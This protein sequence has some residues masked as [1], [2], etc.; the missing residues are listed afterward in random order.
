VSTAKGRPFSGNEIRR[1]L[2]HASLLKSPII[3]SAR[4]RRR[5]AASRGVERMPSLPL[6]PFASLYRV[7]EPRRNL[8]SDPITRGPHLSSRLVSSLG[9]ASL[10]VYADN[11]HIIFA[12]PLRERANNKIA[13]D[14]RIRMQSLI[15]A[16]DYC[17]VDVNCR[18][19]LPVII[20]AHED[21]PRLV[22]QTVSN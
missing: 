10:R 7:M 11:S 1:V 22:T 6:S 18:E 21:Y 3:A 15:R 2:S 17:Q 13:A 9:P 20:I 19:S 5:R 16:G 12:R 4:R 14:R 8:I